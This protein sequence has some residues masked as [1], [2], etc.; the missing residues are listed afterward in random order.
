MS[1]DAVP[2]AVASP[3]TRRRPVDPILPVLLRMAWPNVLVMITQSAVGLI[4][5]LQGLSEQRLQVEG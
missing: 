1:T 5:T 2:A 3:L 4:E